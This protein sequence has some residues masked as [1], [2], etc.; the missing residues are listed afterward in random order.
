MDGQ[1]TLHQGLDQ[2]VEAIQAIERKLGQFHLDLRHFL[3]A[4]QSTIVSK[5]AAAGPPQQAGPSSACL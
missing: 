1:P 2:T 4:T 5:K 3:Q